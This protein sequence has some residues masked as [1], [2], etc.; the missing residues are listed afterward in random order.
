[1]V[2]FFSSNLATFLQK[3]FKNLQFGTG[4]LVWKSSGKLIVKD[5]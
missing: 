1:M 5:G 4:I 2:P 3:K